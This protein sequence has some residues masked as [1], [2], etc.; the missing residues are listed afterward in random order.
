MHSRNYTEKEIEARADILW[1]TLIKGYAPFVLP[2][3]VV[4]LLKSDLHPTTGDLSRVTGK[5]KKNIETAR[6]CVKTKM[7]FLSA[8]AWSTPAAAASGP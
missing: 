2:F 5:G 7:K 3:G 8:R 1:S 4:V 6:A